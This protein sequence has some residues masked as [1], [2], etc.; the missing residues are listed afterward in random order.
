MPVKEMRG[1]ADTGATTAAWPFN[2]ARIE[3]MLE[4]GLVRDAAGG[5]RLKRD[6]G[7]ES[8]AATAAA[9]AYVNTV[10]SDWAVMQLDARFPRMDAETVRALAA[11]RTDSEKDFWSR[12]A[13]VAEKGALKGPPDKK[14]GWTAA[15]KIAEKLYLVVTADLKDV[16]RGRDYHFVMWDGRRDWP[17]AGF[18]SFPDAARARMVLRLMDCPAAANNLVV[19]LHA[20][21]ANRHFY[22]PDYMESLLRR[23]A[24][25]GC[26]TA[27]HNL[28]VLMEEQGEKE[29]AEAFYSRGRAAEGTK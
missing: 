13:P 3:G 2:V 8:K 26:E 4:K 10:I 23:A 18:D 15:W 20:R 11:Y 21:D 6:T 12:F 17:I 24:T 22:V 9:L 25:G 5:Y 1:E 19:L 29:Q 16:C 28:G 7:V 14:D 27:F